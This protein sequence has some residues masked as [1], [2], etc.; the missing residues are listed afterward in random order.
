MILDEIMS[1]INIIIVIVFNVGYFKSF[2]AV[3]KYSHVF[4]FVIRFYCQL[5]LT[6]YST[7]SYV[8]SIA[9]SR[10]VRP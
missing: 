4:A 2:I 6:F 10:I 8:P 9:C 1:L 7:R 5:H 3:A